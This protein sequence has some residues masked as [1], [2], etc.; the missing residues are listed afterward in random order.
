MSCE[1]RNR[2]DRSYREAD[3]CFDCGHRILDK[4][5]DPICE[6]DGLSIDDDYWCDEYE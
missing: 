5:A 4:N 1:I 3:R 6:I 2:E